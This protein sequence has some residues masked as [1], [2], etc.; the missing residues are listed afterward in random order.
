MKADTISGNSHCVS[1][2]N[3]GVQH[4]AKRVAILSQ[5]AR[6]FNSK[7]SRATTL[8]DVAK[9]LGLTKTSLYYYVKNK[10]DL[11]YQCYMSA[12]ELHHKNLDKIEKQHAGA[13]ERASSYF[14]QYFE[15][16][17]E[18][19]EGRAPHVAA[20][21]EIAVL[22]GNHRKRVE[23]SYIKLFKRLR[24]Y[25]SQGITEGSIR[26]CEPTSATRAIVGSIDWTFYW[27]HSVPRG[28]VRAIANEALDIITNGLCA[29]EALHFPTKIF[30][31]SQESPCPQGFNREQKNRLKQEAF[32]KTGNRFFNKQGFNGTSLDEIA[33]D[34]HVSKGAFYYHIKNKE[35]LLFHCYNFSLDIIEK[36]DDRSSKSTATGLE[37]VELT[38]RRIFYVQNS[39]DGPLIRY[40]TI[41][42]LPMARRRQ[43]LKRTE[44]NNK[45]FGAFLSDGIQDGSVRQINT[46]IAQ[47]LITGAINAAMDIRQWR[48]VDDIDDA[49][50]DYFDVFFNGL[51]P[52]KII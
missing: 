26:D 6:L 44:K 43:I 29:S 1:P 50:I 30:H 7:G 14:L 34:L 18:A 38:C 45:N 22:K 37:K 31:E 2:F 47:H 35:D 41:I 19:Q 48:K 39:D 20:L 28:Q 51:A 11:I 17:L 12:L 4:D 24:E 42:A 52:R 16:W 49:A 15:N 46:L 3:R 27:L 5:A 25:I 33:Q 13:M 40:N 9:S 32:F 21:L 36:I 10:E 8:H 23:A